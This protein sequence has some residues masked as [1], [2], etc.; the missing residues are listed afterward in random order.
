[1][2]TLHIEG[3]WER[4]L[5]KLSGLDDTPREELAYRLLQKGLE[6]ELVELET[7]LHDVVTQAKKGGPSRE[8]T[9]TDWA[10]IMSTRPEDVAPDSLAVP[11]G[12]RPT[13]P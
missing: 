11:P 2:V 10:D 4:R 3:K 6:R 7:E 1:M 12:W 9:E 8:L 5:D 13:H